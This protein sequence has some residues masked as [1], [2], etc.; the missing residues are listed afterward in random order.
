MSHCIESGSG[1][2]RA[3]TSAWISLVFVGLLACGESDGPE[4]SVDPGERG[5]GGAQAD[6]GA[7]ATADASADAGP[8]SNAD[9]AELLDL[10]ITK[11]LG[12]AKPTGMETIT[13]VQGV[14][15]GSIV[16]DFDPADGPVCLRGAPYSVSVLDQG[17]ENLMIYL[18]GGGAC[19]SLLCRSTKEVMQRGVPAPSMASPVLGI[20]DQNDA[21]NPVAGWNVVYVPYC[22]G[23]VFGG[24]GDFM[25]P[26]DTEGTRYH[27]GQKNFAAALDLALKHF[28]DPQKVLLAGSSAGGW[29]TVYHR[30]LVRSQYPRAQ[31][32]VFNDAGIGFAVNQPTVADE[33][34]ATRHR[35][36]SC[37]ECQTHAHMTYFV[38]YMLEHD[39]DTWVG[40]FSSYGDSVIRF[41][42]FS[43]D[44]ESF[45]QVLMQ[46]TDML[47]Q[48]FPD[49]Y[50][51]FFVTGESHTTLIRDFHTN[52]IEGVTVAQW[53][54][55]MIDRDPSWAE[56]LQP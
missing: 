4:R 36:P 30:G 11:Y 56:L 38:K 3:P 29:G 14:A 34:T 23:S 21:Q 22:D 35:P 20:L 24:D 9:L 12:A 46:E 40:D 7:R 37:A 17:S 2:R 26:S 18:Q 27:H 42:T 25:N 31:L 54:G 8:S 33:W 1:L 51:R 32:T 49:R 47:A 28:P 16:Y 43:P 6:G 53:L 50:K 52:V 45:K 15:D 5:D 41:F 19:V 10:G 13:G 44:A 39:P 55:K 48:A